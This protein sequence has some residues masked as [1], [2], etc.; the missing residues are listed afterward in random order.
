MMTKVAGIMLLIAGVVGCSDG[1]GDKEPVTIGLSASL[2]GFDAEFGADAQRVAQLAVD[3]IN[4]R[5]GINGHELILQVADDGSDEVV[6]VAAANSLVDDGAVAIVGPFM[7]FLAVEIVDLTDAAEVLVVTPSATAPSLAKSIS[8]GSYFF[9]TTPNDNIQG[10]AMSYYL[11][12]VASPS[13]DRVLVL[14]EAGSY[15]A[16]LS[17]TFVSTFEVNGGSLVG[18]PLAFQPDLSEQDPS[19]LSA[20]WADVAASAPATIVVIGQSSDA[21]LI[22]QEWAAS[23]DLPDV[24][25]FFTDGIKNAGLFEGLPV[26][27]EGRRGTAPTNP[28]TGNAFGYFVDAYFDEYSVD[29]TDSAFMSNTWD[30]VF[31]IAAALYKQSVDGQEF[32]GPELRDALRTVSAGPGVV[33]HA[34]RWNDLTNTLRR[35]GAIDFDGASGPVDIDEFGETIGPYEVW[36]VTKDANDAWAFEQVLFVQ[37]RDLANL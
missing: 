2:T 18:S 20:L 17:E 24:D 27:I 19:V 9:R 10:I 13:V 7:S 3:E 30:A 11:R 29:M 28:T 34:G 23:G 31:L 22:A 6:A 25:W 1:E 36:E 26:E 14:H 21:S 15:G 32:G 8:D 35:G 12:E 16:G 37:A 33:V 4:R 5:G